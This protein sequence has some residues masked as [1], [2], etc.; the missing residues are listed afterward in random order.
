MLSSLENLYSLKITF[1]SDAPG[2]KV[3]ELMKILCEE[4]FYASIKDCLKVLHVFGIEDRNVKHEI[5]SCGW[6]ACV[7]NFSV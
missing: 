5:I 2:E 6:L 7:E 3:V 1:G 4:E